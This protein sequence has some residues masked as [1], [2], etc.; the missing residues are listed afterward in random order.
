MQALR[1][2]LL[3]AL[4]ILVIS[5]QPLCAGDL[6]KEKDALLN[7]VLSTRSLPVLAVNVSYSDSSVLNY[8]TQHTGPL[9]SQVELECSNIIDLGSGKLN[10]GITKLKEREANKE[11]YIDSTGQLTFD[12]TKWV[13]VR[14]VGADQTP[15]VSSITTITSGPPLFLSS[16]LN[17]LGFPLFTSLLTVPYY[18]KT[19][20]LA[21]LLGK[22]E[23][24]AKC[25]SFEI[26]GS[27]LTIVLK[28]DCV[29]DVLSFDMARSFALVSRVTKFGECPGSQTKVEN[30]WTI[31]SF[32]QIDKL[33]L[34]ATAE[35]SQSL[36]GSI[37]VKREYKLSLAKVKTENISYDAPIPA[38]SI[39]SDERFDLRF[40][41]SNTCLLL[42]VVLFR[43][44]IA[45]VSWCLMATVSHTLADNIN[46]P[47]SC[48]LGLLASDIT[49]VSVV[50]NVKNSDSVN[51]LEITSIKGACSCFEGYSAEEAIEPASE[52][53][54]SLHFNLTRFVDD[55][56]WKT[57]VALLGK[58]GKDEVIKAIDLN[59]TFDNLN[60]P[61]IIVV[62]LQQKLI[63][64]KGDERADSKT[65]LFH[66]F[67]PADVMVNVDFSIENPPDLLDVRLVKGIKED[68]RKGAFTEVAEV[69]ATLKDGAKYPFEKR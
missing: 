48:D 64:T 59:A 42:D 26:S 4:S 24:L 8:S 22:S 25:A 43:F 1:S 16:E 55:G 68:F 63:H 36:N 35:M 52:G 11:I 53:K 40:L 12:G 67:A 34:P 18:D 60:Q 3:R 20:S 39:V 58:S 28:I 66:V 10:L 6:A 56:S 13:Y 49:H 44:N 45:T 23:E 69:I 61:K 19:I 41:P 7:S 29:V 33:W 37:K 50:I 17:P 46:V 62:P 15:D 9:K 30:R 57:Q 21:E 31:T 5:Q 2:N 38:K 51:K 14:S 32:Q 27:V 65:V 54:V 47:S